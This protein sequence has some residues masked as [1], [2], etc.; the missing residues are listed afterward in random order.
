[1]SAADTPILNPLSIPP[2]IAIGDLTEISC[3]IKRG[4]LPVKFKWMHNGLDI[5]SH[6]KYK[7]SSSAASSQFF[8][9]EIEASDIGNFT[10]IASN[11]YGSDS[12]TEVVF[13]EGEK[14]ML[15]SII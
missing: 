9:G 12:K 13:M 3:S 11:A 1:M 14:K 4:S 2:N 5:H 15:C 7:I 6:S 10:C 8:I